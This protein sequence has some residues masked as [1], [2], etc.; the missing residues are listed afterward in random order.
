MKYRTLLQQQKLS[1]KFCVRVILNDYV[2]KCLSDRDIGDSFIL[3]HQRHLTE[4]DLDQAWIEFRK[5]T[6]YSLAVKVAK[7]L[8]REEKIGLLE[9]RYKPIL[10]K[11]TFEDRNMELR[12]L[13][14]R[15]SVTDW[16]MF[17]QQQAM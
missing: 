7:D 9:L 10:S 3:K 4:E 6:K 15:M 13:I 11:M 12:R 17:L 8:T 5:E 1:A 14:R 16:Y 2:P